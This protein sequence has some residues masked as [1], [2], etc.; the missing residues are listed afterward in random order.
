MRRVCYRIEPAIRMTKPE[1]LGLSLTQSRCLLRGIGVCGLRSVA[2][3]AE[4][5]GRRSSATTGAVRKY[6]AV[7]SSE[8]SPF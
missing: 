1:R 7:L 3:T 4:R 2:G 8:D 6:T 5:P